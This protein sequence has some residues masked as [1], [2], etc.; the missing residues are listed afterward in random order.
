MG[1]KF[2]NEVMNILI[3]KNEATTQHERDFAEVLADVLYTLPLESADGSFFVTKE[4]ESAYLNG[5]SLIRDLS[6]DLKTNANAIDTICNNLKSYLVKKAN[7]GTWPFSDAFNALFVDYYSHI[8]TAKNLFKKGPYS[9]VTCILRMYNAVSRIIQYNGVRESDILINYMF[10]LV[11]NGR[12][13]VMKAHKQNPVSGRRLPDVEVYV[14]QSV[15]DP[16]FCMKTFLTM[17]PISM[18][19][20]HNRATKREVIPFFDSLYSMACNSELSL[21]KLWQNSFDPKQVIRNIHS[22]RIKH[23][24]LS[25]SALN[26]MIPGDEPIYLASLFIRPY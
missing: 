3:A 23:W 6:S 1:T 22:N 15:L 11:T 4:D 5:M 10:S 2:N 13:V 8:Y 18:F 19:F 14:I 9:R 26:K 21:R 20:G 24:Y 7:G 25:R 17:S 16:N 12:E